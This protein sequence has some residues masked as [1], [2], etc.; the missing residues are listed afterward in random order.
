[1]KKYYCK[2]RNIT[3]G[4]EFC[5]V[6]VTDKPQVFKI[7]HTLEK[8]NSLRYLMGFNT[9]FNYKSNFY[10]VSSTRT[11]VLTQKVQLNNLLTLFCIF[12]LSVEQWHKIWHYALKII[13]F[14]TSHL[15]YSPDWCVTC[16]VWVLRSGTA[17]K[18]R[19]FF[20]SCH[21]IKSERWQYKKYR[22][23]E[24]DLWCSKVYRNKVPI[25]MLATS[26][27]PRNFIQGGV[28]QIQ[29]RTE[30]GDLGAVAH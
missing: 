30:N 29:L 22:T 16:P 10:G 11:M 13:F 2:G 27:V 28:Q 23:P 15:S 26:G 14:D 1:M 21:K 9:G 3:P 19:A 20:I 17:R 12:R 8:L 25:Y 5:T 18:K 6:L 24:L 4:I 7:D